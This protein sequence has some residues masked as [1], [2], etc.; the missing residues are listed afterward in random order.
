[1]I[2]DPNEANAPEPR[3]N[4]VEAG[5]GDDAPGVASGWNGFG[6]EVESNRL[7]NWRICGSLLSGRSELEV[8][9]E[10]LLLVLV[11]LL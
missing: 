9:R 5:A 1:M 3:L 2:A 7:G 8:G 4:A 6:R 10:G 11:F